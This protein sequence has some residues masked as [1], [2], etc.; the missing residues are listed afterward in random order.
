MENA[1]ILMSAH[2]T[3]I[4][5]ELHAAHVY[6]VGLVLLAPLVKIASIVAVLVKFA[7]VWD[8]YMVMSRA[9]PVVAAAWFQATP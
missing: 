7:T 8:A 4:G 9:L 2:V 3:T 6:M 1:L 5:M